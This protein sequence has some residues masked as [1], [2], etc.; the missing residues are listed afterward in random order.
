[1]FFTYTF[2]ILYRIYI[3]IRPLKMLSIR[4]LLFEPLKHG[5][6]ISECIIKNINSVL[7]EIIISGSQFFTKK[8]P[9]TTM[10]KNDV[11]PR[12]QYDAI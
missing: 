12:V 9:F 2:L 8:K 3:E 4:F 1:M 7:I 5:Y 10:C 6:I 11:K